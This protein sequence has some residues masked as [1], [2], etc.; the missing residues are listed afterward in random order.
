MKL[1]Y[2]LLIQLRKFPWPTTLNTLSFLFVL[3]RVLSDCTSR[4]LHEVVPIVTWSILVAAGPVFSK[5]VEHRLSRVIVT[6]FRAILFRNKRL[7]RTSWIATIELAA[8]ASLHRLS[9][10]RGL[11]GLSGTRLL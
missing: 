2:A 8:V 9:V 10:C 5:V 11:C 3:D 6:G 1:S 7:R 4:Q